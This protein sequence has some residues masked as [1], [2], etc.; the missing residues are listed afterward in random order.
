MV[1]ILFKTVSGCNARCTYC[2]DKI[3]QNTPKHSY[4]M[5]IEDFKKMFSYICE[6]WG[7]TIAWCWH[8]GEPLLAGYE[9]FKEAL[10]FMHVETMKHHGFIYHTMQTNGLLFNEKWTSLFDK[11]NVDYSI[12]NDG[13]VNNIT[14]RYTEVTTSNVMCSPSQLG[15]ISPISIDCLIEN[16]EHMK[17]DPYIEHYTQNW[18]FPSNGNQTILDIWGTEENIDKAIDKYIEYLLYYIHDTNRPLNDRNALEFIRCSLGKK[19]S[20]CTFVNCFS[21]NMIV[22]DTNGTV[23]K[24]DEIDN[25]DFKLGY[26]T[27][28]SDYESILNSPKLVQHLEQRSK[29]KDNDCK[30]CDYILACG[31]GCWARA[32]RESNGEHPY[33]FMCKLSKKVLP[34]LYNELCDLTPEEFSK[35][36]IW[37]KRD[38]LETVYI[39][40]SIKQEVIDNENNSI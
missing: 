27:D 7:S 32:S 5:P 29:W 9:W 10:Y 30:D 36:N 12:S 19:P 31:Q 34:V 23:Y 6:N 24:C 40:A 37:V 14:R 11:Y 4:V 25:D 8:G 17:E 20:T 38:L 2:F 28:F 33:S 21:N 16:Y 15:V 1:N 18:I 22:I 35:L 13:I 39:P 3:S 26:Y